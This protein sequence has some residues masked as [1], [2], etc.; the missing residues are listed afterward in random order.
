MESIESRH[1]RTFTPEYKA[2]V[3]DLCRSSGKPVGQVARDLD[4]S[5]TVVRRWVNQAE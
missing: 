3:V 5:E 1:R 4:V 2:E